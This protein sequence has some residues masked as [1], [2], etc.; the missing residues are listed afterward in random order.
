MEGNIQQLIEQYHLPGNREVALKDIHMDHGTFKQVWEHYKNGIKE[1]MTRI[2]KLGFPLMSIVILIDLGNGVYSVVDG[3][4][5]L[6]AVFC[7][8]DK[9]EEIPA[10]PGLMDGTMTVTAIVL[11]AITFTNSKGKLLTNADIVTSFEGTPHVITRIKSWLAVA[12]YYHVVPNLNSVT[13]HPNYQP[14]I[15]VVYAEGVVKG[16]LVDKNPDLAETFLHWLAAL[17]T[18][19]KMKEVKEMAK[20]WG[21]VYIPWINKVIAE[22]ATMPEIT[23]KGS[24]GGKGKE[25]GNP[26][27]SADLPATDADPE[28]PDSLE[29]ALTAFAS[30]QGVTTSVVIIDFPSQ[31]NADKQQLQI[32]IAKFRAMKSNYQ[33]TSAP[34][35]ATIHFE[36]QSAPFSKGNLPNDSTLFA[37][38]NDVAHYAVTSRSPVL[39]N[40][41][42]VPDVD[43]VKYVALSQSK[44]GKKKLPFFLQQVPLALWMELITLDPLGRRRPILASWQDSLLAKC[45]NLSAEKVTKIPSSPSLPNPLIEVPSA[46]VNPF[47]DVEAGVEGGEEESEGSDTDEETPSDKEMIDNGD[48]DE[49]DQD[50]GDQ[51]AGKGGDDDKSDSKDDE[52]KTKY[53]NAPKPKSPNP[54]CALQ[55]L[56]PP[57][58]GKP[59]VGGQ[60]RPT[61]GKLAWLWIYKWE[62]GR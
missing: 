8:I 23:C 51:G 2:S 41:A 27:A 5:R 54:Q 20:L 28:T 22:L 34:T 46:N 30:Q 57:Q 43:I 7:L 56:L 29:V 16:Q 18:A 60:T 49:G 61:Q 55:N 39:L 48:E 9:D 4:H 52:D 47:L 6:I 44:K 31:D 13:N 38:T 32:D 17:P 59:P 45:S 15:D 14:P 21:K 33:T 40:W 11:R 26:S 58:P 35:S 3:N 25:K 37:A 19:A 62:G 42:K 1:L 50:E 12:R 24:T 53:N 10:L 36:F